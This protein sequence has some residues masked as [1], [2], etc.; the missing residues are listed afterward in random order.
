MNT[1][2]VVVIPDVITH[3]HGQVEAEIDGQIAARVQAS[4]GQL[5]GLC[6]R[7]AARQPEGDRIAAHSAHTDQYTV[8]ILVQPVVRIDTARQVGATCHADRRQHFHAVDT[9]RQP[10]ELVIATIGRDG[11]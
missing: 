6:Q 1:V 2:I 8:V 7:Y 5:I 3:A 10:V 4:R 11:R 9:S